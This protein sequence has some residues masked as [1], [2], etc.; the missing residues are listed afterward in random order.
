MPVQKETV[1][2]NFSQGLDTLDDPNQLAIGK[3][4]SLVNSVFVKSNTG[5]VGALKK[6]NGFQA[7]S[8]TVSTISYLTNY[9]GGLIGLGVNTAQ[10]YSSNANGWNQRGYY[11]PI[12]LNVTSLIRNAFNQTA[13]DSSIAP[14]GIGLLAFVTSDTSNPYQYAV[15]D[16]NSG[17][18]LSGPFSLNSNSFTLQGSPKVYVLGS[19]FFVLY[20]TT[21]NFLNCD[22]I[23]TFYPFSFVSSQTID[24]SLFLTQLTY[25]VASVTSTA[26]GAIFDA[27]IASNSIF[28]SYLS[29]L[30]SG[31]GCNV[32]GAKISPTFSVST[33]NLSIGSYTSTSIANAFDQSTNTV[34]TTLGSTMQVTYL[35]N[36][37]NFAQTF[38]PVTKAV[39]SSSANYPSSGFSGNILGI[40]NLTALAE[41][42]VCNSFYEIATYYNQWD[43]LLSS[44]QSV[45]ADNI[46]NR[47]VTSSGVVGSETMIGPELGLASKAFRMNGGTYLFGAYQSNLQSTYFLINSSGQVISKFA[48]GNGG[49]YYYFGVPN[50]S[51]SG[52][53]AFV[54]FLQK[55]LIVPVNTS[56]GSNS[57]FNFI[58]PF[59]SQTGVKFGSFIFS[60]SSISAR[61]TGTT[62]SVNGGFLWN[63]DGLELF[64]NNFF[65]YP[66]VF[67]FIGGTVAPFGITPQQ[68]QYQVIYEAT[69][70]QGNIYQSSPGIGN[71]NLIAPGFLGSVTVAINCSTPRL[72][73]RSPVSISL[74]RWSPLQPIFYKV[75]SYIYTGQQTT[76]TITSTLTVIQTTKA[77][78]L[79]YTPDSITFIDTTPDSK[80]TGNEIL[81][82]SGNVL[83]DTSGPSFIATDVF[84]QRIW[85]ISA[86]DNTLWYS[87]QIVAATP[88]EMVQD[89]ALYIPPVQTALGTSQIPLCL[90]PMDDK[91]II[92]CKNSILFINGTG[93]DNAGANSQYSEPTQIPSQVGC[94]NAQSI[95]Q[96]PY[97]LMFQSDNGI[98][99]LGRDLQVK[100]IGKEV[101]GFNASVVTSATSI[102]GTNEIRF[103]L[104]TGQRL[105]YD[106][107]A[108]QWT[109]FVLPQTIQSSAIYNG[110][111][112][113]LS[114]SGQTFQETPGVYLDGTTPVTMS[115]QTGWINLSGLQGYARA[116]WMDILGTF[117]SPHT[118]TVG[119][120]YDYN[121]AIVQTSTINPSNVVGS[122]SFVEQ[123]EIG[124]QRPQCQSF[125]L[126][127][128]EISSGTAG[129]GV[130]ISGISLT[131]GKKKTFARNIAPKNKV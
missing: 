42:G 70:N 75:G 103:S 97:G 62:L 101:E 37:F 10:T 86:E 124:F 9:N 54:P 104:N 114:Q 63:Y 12:G 84:D 29:S 14:N 5:E 60:S 113:V 1:T 125:Q 120:A 58:N 85:G 109:T 83:E 98:W 78:D 90:A 39:A 21:A 116:Y 24:S 118:Y 59:Y 50:V 76:G 108:D 41:N 111:D 66:E 79:K 7:L 45:R 47:P 49:G 36:N 30:Y 52:N 28:V 27:T 22:Q 46:I 100:Y 65:V 94:A 68:Y 73:Y 40:S 95:V 82:T 56:I 126:T 2:I 102:P 110:L 32:V 89:F 20:G 8:A 128:Q 34:Y 53:Q 69:D 3:F 119:I 74:Y 26:V 16:S 121:P 87:K 71:T 77:G 96:V 131:Y 105:I 127:F 38:A 6:R 51:T 13:P 55:D 122:G 92:F 64:E 93:P 107:L 11:Q 129:A 91:Q 112:T 99:L 44:I 33:A 106:L 88:V 61:Q 18:V 67:N 57:I 48:Y 19:S 17:Q 23:N 115:F 72:G 81:Y 35:G 123:W 31:T 15:F 117:Q 130:M 25:V 4:T 43:I 80:I